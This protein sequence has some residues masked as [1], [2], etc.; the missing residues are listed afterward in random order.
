M[1]LVGTFRYWRNP[2]IQI[3]LGVAAWLTLGAVVGAVIGAWI[4]GMVPGPALRRLFAA[5]LLFAAVRMM[6]VSPKNGGAPPLTPVD[7]TESGA[8]TDNGDP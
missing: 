7:T 5:V 8:S 6:I 3:D 4:A 2:Q 1:A